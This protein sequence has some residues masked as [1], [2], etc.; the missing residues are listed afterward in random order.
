MPSVR[1]A[2]GDAGE[3]L[4]AAFLARRGFRI[5]ARNVRIPRIG[6][7]DIVALDPRGTLAFVEVKTRRDRAFGP[8][9]EAVTPSKLRTI[10]ACAEAWRAVKGWTDRPYRIDVVAI[11]LSGAAPESRHLKD[12]GLD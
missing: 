5:L 3:D 9:E 6:E 10:A 12:L 1:R 4:A 7:L 8:P 2:F 11:D